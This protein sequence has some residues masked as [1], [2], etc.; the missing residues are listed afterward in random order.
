MKKAWQAFKT[1]L[2][3]GRRNFRL[4]FLIYLLNLLTAYLMTMPVSMML[5]KALDQTTASADLLKTFDVTI[6][7]TIIKQYGAGIDLVKLV[8]IFGSFYLF[9][10]I[11]LA[12]G[13]LVIISGMNRF[14]LAGFFSN[15]MLYVRRFFF[16]YLY[17]ILFLILTI[18]I[19]LIAGSLAD[20]F[21]E[22]AAT[23]FWP[24]MIIL[25]ELS[26]GC[27]FLIILSMLLDYSRILIVEHGYNRI[28]STITEA[29]TFI[30][31]NKTATFLVYS[32]YLIILLLTYSLY[33]IIERNIPVYNNFTLFT[34]LL[35][36]QVFIFLRTGLRVSLLGGQFWLYGS[37]GSEPDGRR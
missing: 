24:V 27:A 6:F 9:L 20:T 34:F 12:G 11:F 15:C 4:I 13:I 2:D 37:T 16:L 3:R 1:G 31:H 10:N 19:P 35:M 26:L 23:E 28:L 17:A 33:L 8:L 30:W 22:K 29:F 5:T 18:A 36:T 7:S 32:F 21:T 14:S 25:L